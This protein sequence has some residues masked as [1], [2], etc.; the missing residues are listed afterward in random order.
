MATADPVSIAFIHF[1]TEHWPYLGAGLL[2]LCVLLVQRRSPAP[3]HED[4][5][6][7]LPTPQIDPLV[8]FDWTKTEPLVL[9]PFKPRYHIT[10]GI[11]T[12]T[13]SEI[14]QIDKHYLSRIQLRTALIQHKKPAVLGT[15]PRAVPAVRELYTFLV[16]DYL[17]Q[18]YGAIFHRLPPSPNHPESIT[19]VITGE[20]IPCTPPTDPEEALAIIGR[21]VEEDFLLLLP[22]P[23]PSP[24]ISTT[25]PKTEPRAE[26]FENKQM[27][28]EAF[29]GCF[30][31]GFS[32]ADKFTKSLAAIHVPVPDYTAKLR[33]SMDRYLGR[34]AVGTVV[35]RANWTVSVDGELHAAD[36][37][38]LYEG[39]TVEE[40]EVLDVEKARLRCERQ[41]LFRLPRSNAVVFVVRTYMYPLQEIKEEGSG[42]RMVEAIAGLKAGSSPGFHFYKRAAVWQRAVS[43][44]LVGKG[45][46]C[47]E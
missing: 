9:R 10:M 33:G 43:E 26:D 30:P 46:G 13:L 12:T 4:P 20:T 5:K 27:S 45:G 19:N 6:K 16:N 17:P 21:Q 38:H 37:M 23:P 22:P 15:T 35:K 47:A 44:F 18:R 29:I 28:L 36:S 14:V 41:V 31:N 8:D 39:E 34:L 1:I 2:V 40:V 42:P 24:T 7:N 25:G 11:E 32:W 3:T